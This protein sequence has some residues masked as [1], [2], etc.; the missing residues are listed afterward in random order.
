MNSQ[1]VIDNQVIT[2]SYV[3]QFHQENEQSRRNL[4]FIFSNESN[5][6]VESNQN[7]NFNE[8]K[9]VNLDSISVNIALFSDNE[10]TNKKFIDDSLGGVNI[11][12][13]RPTL[14]NYPKV[15]LGNDTYN[16]TEYDKIQTPKTTIIKTSN[17]GGYL[18]RQWNIKSNDKFNNGKIQNFLNQ[19]KQTVQQETMVQLL[20]PQSVIILCIKR[21][22]LKIMV[23]MF[24]S[25]SNEQMLYKFLLQH[26]TRTDFQF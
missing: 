6:L 10:V 1:A 24:L 23:I 20:Y 7:K 16:L 12:R 2:K 14:Q 15:S 17:S 19:Q 3:D 5:D 8:K 18:L 4:G 26:S 11:L 25:A 13:F 9:V 21:R 22:H